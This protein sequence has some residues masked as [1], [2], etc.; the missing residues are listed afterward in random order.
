[1]YRCGTVAAVLGFLLVLVS[2]GDGWA[3]WI[4]GV[5]GIAGALVIYE[6]VVVRRGSAPWRRVLDLV[7]PLAVLGLFAESALWLLT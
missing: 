4:G 2:G 3:A 5:L 6:V 1:M 7:G